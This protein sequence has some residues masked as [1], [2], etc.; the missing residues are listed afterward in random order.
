MKK[1]LSVAVLLAFALTLVPG[2]AALA[3][4]PRVLT[5]GSNLDIS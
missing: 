3:E 5:I 4:A 2:M 1:L